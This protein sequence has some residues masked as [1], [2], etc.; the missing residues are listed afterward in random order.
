MFKKDAYA[1]VLFWCY[2]SLG[3]TSHSILVQGK[4]KMMSFLFVQLSP[5]LSQ[6]IFFKIVHLL[7]KSILDNNNL[8]TNVLS[9]EILRHQIPN[10]VM[11]FLLLLIKISAFLISYLVLYGHLLS[12]RCSFVSNVLKGI[13]DVI[14]EARRQCCASRLMP[15]TNKKRLAPLPREA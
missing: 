1:I 5:T 12:S 10:Q 4:E 14:L 2:C 6:S 15:S 13:Q 8:Q 11:S 7:L 9:H 3:Q